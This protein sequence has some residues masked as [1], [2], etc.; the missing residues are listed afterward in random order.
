MLPVLCSDLDPSHKTCLGWGGVRMKV[1]SEFRFGLFTGRSGW[2]WRS[3]DTQTKMIGL[4]IFGPESDP[5]NGQIGS[6]RVE[7]GRVRFGLDKNYGF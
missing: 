2:V 4:E 5:R 1:E 7:F 3:P 6:D